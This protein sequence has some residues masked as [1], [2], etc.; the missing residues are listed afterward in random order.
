MNF[1]VPRLKIRTPHGFNTSTK[2]KQYNS[3]CSMAGK[4]GVEERVEWWFKGGIEGGAK[5]IVERGAKGG[6][7]GG[8]MGGVIEEASNNEFC[9]IRN[10][11]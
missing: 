1:G 3:N 4:G 10:G 6:A 5:E 2:T 8:V 9:T 7:K 11:F